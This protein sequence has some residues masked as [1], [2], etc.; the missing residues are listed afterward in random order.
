MFIVQHPKQS[1][2]IG[3]ITVMGTCLSFIYYVYIPLTLL[4]TRHFSQNQVLSIN[5]VSLSLVIILIPLFGKFSDY[6]SRVKLLKIICLSVSLLSLPFFWAT[7]YGTYFQILFLTLLISI[8]S[9][10]FFS[11]YPT[12][13]IERFPSKI[14]CTTSSLIYQIV[15]SFVLGILP[16]FV[17][18]L[19]HIT[20]LLYSPAYVLIF[21]SL[22]GF[23]G[24]VFLQQIDTEKKNNS[25]IE[26]EMAIKSLI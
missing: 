2:S 1:I 13:L 17:N 16:L 7:S 25:N 21:S 14:R 4:T 12:I 18:Y 3:A 15:F 6:Y 5:V 24:I 19:T 10:C 9:S 22:L 11:L 26:E 20:Q 8:P 23:I